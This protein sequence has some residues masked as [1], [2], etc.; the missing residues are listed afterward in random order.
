[1]NSVMPMLPPKSGPS[2]RE[3]MKYTPP[4]RIRRLDAM[5]DRL[6]EVSVVMVLDSARIARPSHNP[7]WP[8]TNPVRMN[9][10]TPRMVS[11]QGVNTPPKVP[12]RA[13]GPG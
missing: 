7:A 12:K 13:C 4:T 2:T 11:T 1:M 8:V 9:M 6:N 3:I 5:A 10:I